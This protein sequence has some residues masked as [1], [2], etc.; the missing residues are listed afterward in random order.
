MTCEEQLTEKLFYYDVFVRGFEIDQVRM[1][2]D[3]NEDMVGIIKGN[4]ISE[5]RTLRVQI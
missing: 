4:E 5:N 3:Q 2:S 1:P